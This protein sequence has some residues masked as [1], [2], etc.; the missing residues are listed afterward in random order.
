MKAAI[1]VDTVSLAFA[2]LNIIL[3]LSILFRMTSVAESPRAWNLLTVGMA[4]VIIHFSFRVFILVN[5][6]FDFLAMRLLSSAASL[7]GFGF[8]FGGIYHVWEVV[9]G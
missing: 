3:L 9:Y 2:S 6:Y 4:L 8:L 7:L 1:L 5:P